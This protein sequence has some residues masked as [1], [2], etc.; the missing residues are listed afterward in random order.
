MSCTSSVRSHTAS[1]IVVDA[2]P[3]AA[4][5]ISVRRPA[6]RR[7]PEKIT[8][9]YGIP[10]CIVA[11]PTQ[12]CGQRIPRL[13][14]PFVSLPLSARLWRRRHERDLPLPQ[15]QPS[16]ITR[17]AL[18][19]PRGPSRRQETTLHAASLAL[20]YTLTCLRASRRGR[21]VR[22]RFRRVVGSPAWLRSLLSS[23][24]VAA[25]SRAHPPKL[26]I[27]SHHFVLQVDGFALFHGGFGFC[28]DSSLGSPAAVHRQEVD[29]AFG[30][31][32]A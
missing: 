1:C 27:P 9:P 4:R 22:P 28:C 23:A 31:F 6:V 13:R 17:C 11:R 8:K 16:T 3:W 20:R 21:A 29:E 15:V 30:A 2:P 24:L 12:P 10:C 32:D 19:P 7:C 14:S 26:R 25:V 5:S 18:P